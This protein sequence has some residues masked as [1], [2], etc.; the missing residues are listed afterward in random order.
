VNALQFRWS[1]LAETAR[2]TTEPADAEALSRAA[3]EFA[4]H[5]ILEVQY[6]TATKAAQLAASQAGNARNSIQPA[7]ARE[8]LERVRSAGAEHQRIKPAIAVLSERPDDPDANDKLG[9]FLCYF[10]GQWEKGLPHLAKGLDARFKMIVQ[11]EQAGASAAQDQVRLAEAYFELAE[12]SRN[13]VAKS[14]LQTRSLHWYE[15]ALPQL[16]GLTRTRAGPQV[17]YLRQATNPNLKLVQVRF[18]TLAA[19]NRFVTIQGKWEVK[20]GELLGTGPSN[21]AKAID[22]HSFRSISRVVLRGRIALPGK[23]NLRLAAGPVSLIFNWERAGENPFRTNGNL[24]VTSPHALVPGKEH[25]IEL[26]QTGPR[27]QLLLDSRVLYQSEA[28][29]WGTVAVWPAEGSTIAIRELSIL[30]VVDPSVKVTK[31]S[32]EIW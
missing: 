29:L 14:A 27:V 16:E 4:E 32:H 10:K 13:T 22:E 25:E 30:G 20:G 5:A 19:L 31:P 1:V 28:A 3:L 6:E 2:F 8:W 9:Q 18:S 11:L 26:I 12:A 24:T 15:K 23:C 7:R 21:I 17:A